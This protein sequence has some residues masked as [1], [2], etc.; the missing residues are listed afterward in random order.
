MLQREDTLA[1]GG[2]GLRMQPLPK[3]VVL[4]AAAVPSVSTRLLELQVRTVLLV[5][6]MGRAELV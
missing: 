4:P 2:Q 6:A 1:V 5:R 3:V